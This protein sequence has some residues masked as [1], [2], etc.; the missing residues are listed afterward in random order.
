MEIQTKLD[1]QETAYQMLD[2]IPYQLIQFE[3]WLLD[4]NLYGHRS[5]CSRAAESF[6]LNKS[7]VESRKPYHRIPELCNPFLVYCLREK[8]VGQSSPVDEKNRAGRNRIGHGSPVAE[9]R[10]VFQSNRV[11]AEKNKTVAEKNK[12]VAEKNRAVAGMNRVDHGSPVVYQSN[13]VG[14]EKN[15]SLVEKN[16]AVFDKRTV[17][18]SLERSNLVLAERN[19]SF[20][21]LNQRSLESMESSLKFHCYFVGQLFDC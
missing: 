11:V 21:S 18:G 9:S 19:H 20:A 17:V 8:R 10:A 2:C 1:Y 15:R 16:R 14:V 6:R 7:L 3:A 13:R 12:A 4:C 5:E